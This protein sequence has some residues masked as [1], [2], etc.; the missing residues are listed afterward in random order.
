MPWWVSITDGRYKYIRNLTP[1][2]IDELYDIKA[3][4]EEVTNLAGQPAFDKVRKDMRAKMDAELRRTDGPLF[5]E[6]Q[7]QPASS[8]GSVP[9]LQR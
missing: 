4:P 8:I 5:E 1:G 2:E 6:L 9:G 7:S 3:D